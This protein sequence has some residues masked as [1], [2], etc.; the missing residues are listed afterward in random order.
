MHALPK[1]M[2]NLLPMISSIDSISIDDQNV[3]DLLKMEYSK[4][5]IPMLTSARVLSDRLA[6]FSITND[7]G[8]PFQFHQL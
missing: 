6:Y 4:W 2:A 1:L 5:A 7:H 3:L 8:F